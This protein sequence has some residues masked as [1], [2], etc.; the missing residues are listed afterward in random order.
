ML[1]GKLLDI[2]I[3]Q[4]NCWIKEFNIRVNSVIL[5]GYVSDND[6]VTLYQTC[7]LFVFPSFHEG[8]GLPILEAM[9]CGAPAI[10]SN[11][12]SIP[13]IIGDIRAMFDPYDSDSIKNLIDKALT[14]KSFN[15]FLLLSWP[16]NFT[17]L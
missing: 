5:L 11:C 10:G 8:F 3:E 16:R 6:L 2:E 14:N 4:I 17:L 13:E 15:S 9:S 12:T 7:A 1:A